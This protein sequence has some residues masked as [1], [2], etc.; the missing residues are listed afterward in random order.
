MMHSFIE[1]KICITFLHFLYVSNCQKS[2]LEIFS[3]SSCNNFFIQKNI[4]IYTNSCI[5]YYANIIHVISL[6]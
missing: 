5:I 2:N 3:C 1:A 6:Q 4:Y